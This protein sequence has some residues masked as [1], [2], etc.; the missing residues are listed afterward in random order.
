MDLI[1]TNS[2]ESGFPF[3]IGGFV[4]ATL[5]CHFI[6]CATKANAMSEYNSTVRTVGRCKP[7]GFLVIFSDRIF[8]VAAIVFIQLG[9]VSNF[10]FVSAANNQEE[11]TI[12]VGMSTVLT[13][14]AAELGQE[15]KRGVLAAFPSVIRRF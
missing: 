4:G 13:G 8:C 1:E 7:F 11:Q 6:F 3:A 14:P 10:S 5:F 12:V 2:I 9:L 15:V